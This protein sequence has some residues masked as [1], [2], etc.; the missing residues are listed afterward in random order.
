MSSN[1]LTKIAIV[2]ASG[3]VGKY[4][5][6]SLLANGKHQVMAI[7]RADSK[8]VFPKGVVIA[9]VDYDDQATLVAALQGQDAL[10]ITMS[11]AAPPGQQQKL[12]AAAAEAKVPWILPNEW[13][14][15]YSDLVG[16][17]VLIGPANKAMR[18]YIEE[19]GVSSWI[20]VACGFWYE[21]SLVGMQEQ[22]G[23]DLKNR[24]VMLYDDG[25]TTITTS[26]W[27][28]C[29]EAVAA[30]LALPV[31]KATGVEGPVLEDWRNKYTHF[32][33]FEIS[34][35]DMF[36]SLKRVTGTK[37]EDWKVSTVP[38]ED[39]YKQGRDE[40]A[41]GS[42]IGFAKALY[43]RMFFKDGAGNARVL[44]GLDDEK[45][46]LS[47]EVLD[48]ATKRAVDMYESGLLGQSHA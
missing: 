19:L 22:F 23:F 12:I 47:K 14:G 27:Q 21:F 16:Q 4:V 30:L 28:K 42:R 46:G 31:S 1:H 44:T 9:K 40:L 36:E 24:D 17:E 34:Q 25:T 33:S 37:E 39:Y 11:V 13:G 43:G 18:E 10:I 3:S 5:V 20:G 45:L 29:G 6:A 32:S 48:D 8:A 41:K 7:T 35:R 15:E 38:V 2:G 26:T